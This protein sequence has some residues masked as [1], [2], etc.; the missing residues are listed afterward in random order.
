M[1]QKSVK[2]GGNGELAHAE[3]NEDNKR[4]SAKKGERDG[5]TEFIMGKGTEQRYLWDS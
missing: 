1:E 4:E 2:V 3:T 5:K